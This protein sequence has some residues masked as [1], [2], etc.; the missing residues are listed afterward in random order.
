M[1]LSVVVISYYILVTILLVSM[2]KQQT[3]MGFFLSGAH[4]YFSQLQVK[5]EEVS[6]NYDKTNNMEPT[7]HL[8]IY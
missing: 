5:P 4:A 8:I 2:S 6:G 1:F 3:I 7:N